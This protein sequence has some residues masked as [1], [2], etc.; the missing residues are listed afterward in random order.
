MYTRVV[1]LCDADDVSTTVAT[2]LLE[3]LLE[4]QASQPIVHVCL[5]GGDTANAM[6]AKFAELADGSELDASQLQLWWGCRAQA[7]CSNSRRN[8]KSTTAVP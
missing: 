5:T 1:R 2:R 7:C 6:Y 8:Q 3:R 4:L